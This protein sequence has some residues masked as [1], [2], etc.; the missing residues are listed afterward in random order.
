MAGR[1]YEFEGNTVTERTAVGGT[2]EDDGIGKRGAGLGELLRTGPLFEVVRR[3]YD[4]LAVDAYVEATEEEMRALRSRL[5]TLHDRYRACA[6]ALVATRRSPE[7][8]AAEILS[9]A[10][11]EADARIGNVVAL[12]EAAMVARDEARRERALAVADREAAR[13]EAEEMLAAARA[14]Q[15]EA[16]ATA[17]LRLAALESDMADLRRQRDEARA[18]LT[19]LT[20]QI[21][22][23]LQSLTAVLPDDARALAPVPETGQEAL[24]G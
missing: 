13:Q 1:S 8:R 6:D 3:G 14:A 7:D 24:A 5:H 15:A 19:R 11:T 4:R 16:E 2:R 20:G 23:A 10:R 18:Y 12:R 22:Q 17:S 9:E 21:E